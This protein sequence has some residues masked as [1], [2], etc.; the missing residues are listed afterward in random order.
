M[1]QFLTVF[2]ESRFFILNKVADASDNNTRIYILEPFIDN[3][4]F[5]GAKIFAFSHI[6]LYFT[7]MANGCS[8]MYNEADMREIIDKSKLKINKAY[9][10]IGKYDYTLLECIKK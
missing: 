5:E 7:C 6:S 4:I 2:Q 3:Q 9:Y 8:K 1:S 10:N